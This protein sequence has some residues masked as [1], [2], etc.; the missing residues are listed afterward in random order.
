MSFEAAAQSDI[1][2]ILEEE[3]VGPA[4]L[5]PT[6]RLDHWS[7]LAADDD[8]RASQQPQSQTYVIII[9]SHRNSRLCIER[10]GRVAHVARGEF[11]K[12]G[13]ATAFARY[14]ISWTDDGLISVGIGGAGARPRLV[15]R[16][17]DPEPLRRVRCVGL[18]T[19][20]DWT[21]FRN[22]EIASPPGVRRRDAEDGAECGSS[23]SHARAFRR[24]A[25][26]AA[27][28]TANAAR[29]DERR[30]NLADFADVAVVRRRGA[31]GD[32]PG[33]ARVLRVRG[34]VRPRRGDFG[35]LRRRRDVRRLPSARRGPGC[36]V[37]RASRALRGGGAAHREPAAAL[38]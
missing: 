28:A 27:V 11:I 26:A 9:G 21:S 6:R 38:C 23:H 5:R 1:T 2:C 18:S 15:H 16:W 8:R 19:W 33:A 31:S 36:G 34:D 29:D 35:A 13:A 4:R 24:V 10:N 37:P 3:H 30:T 12:P 32:V 22:I 7:G 14:W 25:P 17:R 20:D